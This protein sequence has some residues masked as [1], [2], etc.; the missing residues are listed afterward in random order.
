MKSLSR[1]ENRSNFLSELVSQNVAT[2]MILVDTG[3]YCFIVFSNSSSMDAR[4]I[5]L[6]IGSCIHKL[7]TVEIV[8]NV[9]QNCSNLFKLQY[10]TA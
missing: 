1:T 4:I 10:K 9:L 6:T 3:R 2:G 5:L 7:G 8:A